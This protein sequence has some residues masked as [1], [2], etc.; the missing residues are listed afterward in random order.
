MPLTEKGEKVMKSMKQ[1][2]GEKKGESVFYASANKGTITGVH[3]A[4]MSLPATSMTVAEINKK[5]EQ[6]WAPTYG[7]SS[8]EGGDQTADMRKPATEYHGMDA[9]DNKAEEEIEEQI[10]PGKRKEAEDEHIGF[11]KIEGELAHKKGVSN[12]KAVA[13]AIGIKKYGKAGMEAKAHAHD[14][15]VSPTGI[16][17]PSSHEGM[18][19]DDLPEQAGEV[20]AAI[21]VPLPP[22]EG[23]E[24]GAKD[25]ENWKHIPIDPKKSMASQSAE[26]KLKAIGN[27]S[28]AA[29]KLARN[30]IGPKVSS[31]QKDSVLGE[32]ISMARAGYSAEKEAE[33]RAEQAHAATEMNR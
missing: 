6:Y 28:P 4:P 31:A 12:P 22:K 19:Q 13:A 15:P 11:K 7:K 16:G 32:T 2:Y 33:G 17:S 25:E 8:G 1:E 5:N 23:Y 18:A 24:H 30:M 29:Q 20:E 14:Q 3:D 21:P 10:H 26:I 9:F 27:M